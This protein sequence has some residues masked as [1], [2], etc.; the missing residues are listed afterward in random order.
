MFYV[1]P[2]ADRN[3]LLVD[4]NSRVVVLPSLPC[5]PHAQRQGDSNGLTECSRPCLA[6]FGDQPEIPEH[7][8][9]GPLTVMNARLSGEDSGHYRLEPPS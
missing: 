1:P 9:A 3:P 5:K 6:G 8:D 2:E 7:I 4:C